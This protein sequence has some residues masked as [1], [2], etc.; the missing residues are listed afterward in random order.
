VRH[1][2]ILN[3]YIKIVLLITRL[4]VLKKN[5]AEGKNLIRDKKLY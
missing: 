2:Q 4:V 1:R 3:R 5:I